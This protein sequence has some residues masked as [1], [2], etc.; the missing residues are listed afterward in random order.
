MMP[1]AAFSALNRGGFPQPARFATM[2][3]PRGLPLNIRKPG[4]MLH[5]PE[6]AF[7]LRRHDAAGLAA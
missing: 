1:G 7:P 3:G 5:F 6:G 2:R 4:R